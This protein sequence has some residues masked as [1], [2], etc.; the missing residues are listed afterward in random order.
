[1]VAA[2]LAAKFPP[3]RGIFW[4]ER[5][6]QRT[7]FIHV[8][9]LEERSGAG[10]FA[11][12][13]VCEVVSL[14]L[15]DV[16]AKNNWTNEELNSQ[17]VGVLSLYTA[18]CDLLRTEIRERCRTSIYPATVDSFQGSERDLIRVSTVVR[19]ERINLDF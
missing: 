1:M 5:G 19:I 8:D 16:L 13:E 14:I 12:R 7:V 4:P 9:G 17:K 6:F 15:K 11:N 10:S 18:Q 2:H 3:I